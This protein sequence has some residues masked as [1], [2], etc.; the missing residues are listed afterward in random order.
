MKD[1]LISRETAIKALS[2]GE[3]CGHVCRNAIKRIPSVP[4]VTLDELCEW[5]SENSNNIPCTYCANFV[6]EYCTAM[7]DNSRPCPSS[8]DD[9]RQAITKWMEEQHD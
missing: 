3:G 1:D 4:A 8:A 2:R 6:N 9:W 5:L 7:G